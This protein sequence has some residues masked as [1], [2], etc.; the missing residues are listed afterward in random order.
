M[1]VVYRLKDRVKVKIDDIEIKVSPLAYSQKIEIQEKMTLAVKES[2]MRYAMEGTI[3]AIKY[4]LKGVSG[5]TNADGTSY[6]LEFDEG[7]L[8]DET[9]DDLLNLKYSQKLSAVCASLL[10]GVGNDVI[11]PGTGEKMEGISFEVSSEK[12]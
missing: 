5:L 10:S 3:L 2:N 7:T 4:A 9:I 6:E 12:K 11:D 8:S 1:S